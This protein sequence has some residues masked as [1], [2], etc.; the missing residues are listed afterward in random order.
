MGVAND[1]LWAHKDDL[2]F[3]QTDDVSNNPRSGSNGKVVVHDVLFVG[4]LT[5]DGTQNGIAVYAHEMGHALGIADLYD[6]DPWPDTTSRGLGRWGLMSTGTWNTPDEPSHMIAW[7]K[8]RLG[9]L[10]YFNVNF[11]QTI[12]VPWVETTPTAI[13]ART[14]RPRNRSRA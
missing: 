1:N 4:G 10:N 12:C 7:C 14:D 9:W 13:R 2:S 3:Y 5:C 8:E 6:L 11:D